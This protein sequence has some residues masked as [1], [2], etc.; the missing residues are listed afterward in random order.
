MDTEIVVLIINFAALLILLY[1]NKKSHKQISQTS[2]YVIGIYAV[3]AFFAILYY[4]TPIFQLWHHVETIEFKSMLYWLIVFFLACTPLIY[5]D[6][7]KYSRIL[8]NKSLVDVICLAGLIS[9]AIYL[10]ENIIKINTL[11]SDNSLDVFVELHDENEKTINYSIFSRAAR[12]VLE[13]IKYP[14]YVLMF[15]AITEKKY[16]NLSGCIIGILSTV[17]PAVLMGSRGALINVIIVFV[18]I[19]LLFSPYFSDKD[20]KTLK[21][22][23]GIVS[24]VALSF[25]VVITIVRANDYSERNSELTL[26]N[27]IIRYAGEGFTNFYQ[28]IDEIRNNV[29][30]EYCFSHIYDIF[31]GN[32]HVGNTRDYLSGPIQ[33]LT[34]IPMMQF[35]TFIGFFVI[36]I[37]MIGTI[38]LWFLLSRLVIRCLYVNSSNSI[39]LSHLLVLFIYSLI[40]INGLCIYIFSW[41]NDIQLYKALAVA[42]IMKLSKS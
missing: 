38:I 7:Q 29:G 26:F 39:Y 30:G 9:G 31:I 22:Y 12:F 40:I 27:F 25:F 36:D 34:G 33:S 17:L 2:N 21:K 32:S 13:W 18:F 11:L 19:Y 5:Y 3:S 4:Y 42:G 24:I 35:Y 20:Q 28:Y 16:L 14:L 37:G 23:G 10:S 15:P 8:Y 41:S 6:Q 1:W